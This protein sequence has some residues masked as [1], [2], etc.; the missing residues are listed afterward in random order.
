VRRRASLLLHVLIVLGLTF[1]GVMVAAPLP[2]ETN[3]ARVAAPVG[4][5]D[6]PDEPDLASK[7]AKRRQERHQD[8]RQDRQQDHKQDRTKAERKQRRQQDR[9]HTRKKVDQPRTEPAA[10]GSWKQF[11]TGPDLIRLQESEE[12]THG[13]DP[14]PPGFDPKQPAR[15]LAPRAAAQA[16]D[17]LSCDGD[18]QS[19]FRV[20]VLYVHASDR[21]SRFIAFLPS[22]QAWAAEADQIFQQSANET[23]P[24]RNLRFVH[25]ASC[26]PIIEE[27]IV[28]PAGDGTFNA[29]I[30]ELKD[31]GYDRTDRNYLAFVDTVSSNICGIG[32]IW[33]DDRPDGSVNQNNVGPRYARVDARAGCWDGY[34]A[35]HEIMHNL[36]GVQNTAPN[37]S[38][39]FHCIDEYDVMCYSDE[40][41][42]PSMRVDCPDF[43]LDNTRFDCGHQDYYDTSPDAGSYLATHWNPANNRFLIGAPQPP[44]DTE[45]PVVAWV[46]PV[47]NDQEHMVSSGTVVLEASATDDIGVQSVE[48]WHYHNA[49]ETWEKIT[50]DTTAPYEASM[51]VADLDLGVN[52]LFTQA[53]DHLLRVSEGHQ[54]RVN[55]TDGSPPP[56]TVSPPPIDDSE[57]PL[58]PKKDKKKKRKKGKKKR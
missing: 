44:L 51:D 56:T 2:V 10:Q 43:G 50:T 36:G 8:R 34:V 15:P 38:L 26:Q 6:G 12:C 3:L 42:F 1:P 25:N 24:T 48:F 41:Y 16:A 40:P 9:K 23:G 22:F 58:R 39:G 32:N 18:G 5:L 17:A 20:Q 54:I 53:F 28:S 19:G 57:Q 47:G 49:T 37:A 30:T 55:R 29:T 11:C 7:R 13:P 46:K 31:R 35:A 52:F 4:R 21:S 14:V 45:V 27:V 33:V